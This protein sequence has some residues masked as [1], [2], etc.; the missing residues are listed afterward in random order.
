MVELE[1]I[2][3]HLENLERVARENGNTRVMGGPGYNASMEY[4][5]ST[6]KAK[7]TGLD[8]ITGHLIPAAANGCNA[9]TDYEDITDAV[10]AGL[11]PI[12]ALVERG[13]CLCDP[14]PLT[15]ACKQNKERG[16]EEM[17]RR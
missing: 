12:V 9:T 14:T 5:L 8:V 1:G 17:W 13:T 4:V 11:G 7:A 10:S 6:L 2:R 3:G 16:W 15:M